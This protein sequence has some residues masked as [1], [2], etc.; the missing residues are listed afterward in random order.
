VAA[1]VG[2]C[3]ERQA[4]E[5]EAAA[6]LE[7]AID[8]RALDESDER[9]YPFTIRRLIGSDLPYLEPLAM[10]NTLLGDLISNKPIGV[11]SARFH[12]GLAR[13]IAQMVGTLAGDSS[14]PRFDTVVLSGGCFQNRVLFEQCAWRLRADGFAVLAHARVPTNDGGLALGQAAVAAARYLDPRGSPCV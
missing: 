8:P 11:M 3:F 6:R 1:A 4:Y 7:A 2:I 9:A 14:A 12:R 5:G 10:W 13:G